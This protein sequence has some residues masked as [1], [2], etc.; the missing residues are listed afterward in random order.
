MD[1]FFWVA[2]ET[3]EKLGYPYLDETD[4]EVTEWVKTCLSE[5]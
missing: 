4:K 2:A 3:A 1:V 5:I